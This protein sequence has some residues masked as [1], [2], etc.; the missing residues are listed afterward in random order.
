MPID[1]RKLFEKG[2]HFGHQT[3]RWCPKMAPYIWG[4]KN[5]THLFDVSITASQL[6]KA[7][8]FLETIAAQGQSILWVGTKRAAQ[9]IIGRVAAGKWPYV[10]HRWIGGT[11]T[12][13]GQVKKSVTK[14]KHL[15]DVLNKYET[16]KDKESLSLNY[17][18]KEL[19]LLQKRATRLRKSVGGIGGLTWPIGA[20][21]IVD[22]GK[23]QSALREA[24]QMK[25]PVVALVDTN[26]DPSL[27]TYVI[28]ANDDSPDAIEVI[29]SY[30][31]EAADRGKVVAATQ[32]KDL[33]EQE[34]VGQDE[35][36][37]DVAGVLSL[38]VE[39]DE[40]PATADKKTKKM[41]V[42]PVKSSPIHK[43]TRSHDEGD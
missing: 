17:T 28:P 32:H 10:N 35:L 6:E 37:P 20:V 18:K 26:Y 3:S 2:V 1:F 31:A 19:N 7:A 33:V 12:N 21:V 41:A 30:L 36:I 5:K 34:T 9:E 22:I 8:Q 25:I 14:H 39:E 40:A 38:V 16:V 4:H 24:A 29:V 43:K 23:E 15:E 27:V 13:F 11:L 42:A